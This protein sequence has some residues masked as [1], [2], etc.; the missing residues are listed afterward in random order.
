FDG[1]RQWPKDDRIKLY[2][3]EEIMGNEADIFA[4]IFSFYGLSYPRVYLSKIFAKR[5]SASSG[6]GGKHVRDA[7][8]Q[9]WKS[10]FTKKVNDYFEARYADLLEMYGY[11]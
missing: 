7:K 1:M 4:D 11:R 3:Y 5:Y 6:K 10:R 8:P 2:K 9:Q